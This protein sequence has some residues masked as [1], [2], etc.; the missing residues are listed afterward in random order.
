MAAAGCFASKARGMS[1]HF[2]GYMPNQEKWVDP[3][4]KIQ[5]TTECST[6][7]YKSKNPEILESLAQNKGWFF[8]PFDGERCMGHCGY[9]DD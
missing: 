8:G 3:V 9:N 7:F 6:F 5:R 2:F 4:L 1:L